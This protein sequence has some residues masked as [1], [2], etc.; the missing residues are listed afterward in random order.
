MEEEIFLFLFFFLL[1]LSSYTEFR[2]LKFV[3]PKTKVHILDE[4]Y[5]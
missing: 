4:R 5:A 1:L 2:P 3:G